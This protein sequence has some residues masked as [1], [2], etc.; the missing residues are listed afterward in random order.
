MCET[1][2]SPCETQLTRLLHLYSRRYV[3][4]LIHQERGRDG[5][6]EQHNYDHGHDE[7]NEEED[8]QLDDCYLMRELLYVLF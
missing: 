3:P 8:D 5:D 4:Q 7:Q 6:E 2:L 1:Q